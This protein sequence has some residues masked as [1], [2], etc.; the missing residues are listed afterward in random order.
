KTNER[1]VSADAALTRDPQS[2]IQTAYEEV[3]DF[4][5]YAD[6]YI[7]P[8]DRAAEALAAELGELA[9]NRL[10]RLIRY[11]ADRHNIRVFLTPPSK[12]DAISQFDS[13]GRELWVSSRLEPSTQFFQIASILGGLE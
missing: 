1:L 5:H 12:G 10:Q 4:F 9:P 11:C 8:L 13:V 3:R 2:G 6:N 7:D